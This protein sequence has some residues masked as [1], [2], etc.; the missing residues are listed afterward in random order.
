MSFRE[1]L[2]INKIATI[3]TYSVNDILTNHRAIAAEIMEQI[4][5]P[6][7]HFKSYLHHGYLPFGLVK[8]NEQDYLSRVF[9]IID[10]CLAYD[11]AFINDYSAEHQS[12]IKRLLGILSETVPY[13]PN[14]LELATQLQ[15]GRNTLLMLLQHLE[16]ASLINL[17]NKTGK[18]F[19]A[20]QKPDKIT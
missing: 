6:L 12:K 16:Q 8:G 17:I 7:G 3:K 19:S 2:I 20:L 4:E 5:S 18:G 11:L 1:Y 13:I 9:Q 15:I 14:I 10:A